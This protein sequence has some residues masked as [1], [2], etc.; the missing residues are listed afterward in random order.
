M[1]S[2]W[3]CCTFS[4]HFCSIFPSGAVKTCK[5]FNAIILCSCL[6]WSLCRLEWDSSLCI[7]SFTGRPMSLKRNFVSTEA[8]DWQFVPVGR[9][10]SKQ[11]ERKHFEVAG[12]QSNY[13]ICYEAALKF[14]L[15]SVTFVGLKLEKN[16]SGRF[17]TDWLLLLRSQMMAY[18]ARGR[19]VNKTKYWLT[20]YT[21]SLRQSFL[22]THVASW[23]FS[24]AGKE[25]CRK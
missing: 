22:I 2:T 15:V 13:V 10:C 18:L 16:A 14:F 12:Y 11:R 23:S 1:I 17:I 7:Y 25:N 21:S 6:K 5:E 8:C 19:K 3:S 4:Y 9:T 20:Q 24:K